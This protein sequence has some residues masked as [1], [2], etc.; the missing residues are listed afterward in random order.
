MTGLGGRL[1]ADVDLTLGQRSHGGIKLQIDDGAFRGLRGIHLTTD[2]KLD[3]RSFNGALAGKV[4][5]LGTATAEWTTE[6]EGAATE[7]SSY[8]HATG[9]LTAEVDG[10]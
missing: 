3:G 7:V 8:E 1:G 9:D 6:L 10:L 4:D 5:G 2:A